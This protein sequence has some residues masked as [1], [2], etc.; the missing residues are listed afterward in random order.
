MSHIGWEVFLNG[1]YYDT[2]FF[3]ADMDEDTVKKSLINHDNYD[4]RIR[5]YKEKR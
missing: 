3:E 4:P 1:K 5:I 2:V